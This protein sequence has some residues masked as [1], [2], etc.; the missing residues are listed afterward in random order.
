MADSQKAPLCVR[1]EQYDFAFAM[2]AD[3]AFECA[4]V[5]SVVKF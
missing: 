2:F 3:V 4:K 5:M 1:L